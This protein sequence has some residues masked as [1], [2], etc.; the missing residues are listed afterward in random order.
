MDRQRIFVSD[1]RETSYEFCG[2]IWSG[3]LSFLGESLMIRLQNLI[4]GRMIMIQIS[5]DDYARLITCMRA[6]NIMIVALKEKGSPDKLPQNLERLDTARQDFE[7]S[8]DE[9]SQYLK[10][11]FKP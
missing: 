2:Q 1:G 10:L 4:R 3:T 8:Q 5:E 6:A 11:T 9:M 7:H